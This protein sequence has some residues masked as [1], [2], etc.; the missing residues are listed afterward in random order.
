MFGDVNWEIIDEFMREN[1]YKEDKSDI[2]Y[3]LI[4]EKLLDLFKR[5]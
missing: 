4:C 2:D 3:K 5:I 1:F